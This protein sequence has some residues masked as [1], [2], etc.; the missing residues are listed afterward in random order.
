MVLHEYSLLTLLC[1]FETHIF[2]S[3]LRIDKS[4]CQA[5]SP[6]KPAIGVSTLTCSCVWKLL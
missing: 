2:K 4:R 3:S 6:H 1:T 5:G